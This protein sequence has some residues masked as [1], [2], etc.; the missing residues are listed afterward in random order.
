M[1][2]EAKSADAGVSARDLR[3]DHSYTSDQGQGDQNDGC[4][5]CLVHLFSALLL[6]LEPLLFTSAFH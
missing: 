3:D 5:L 2:H 1:N 6:M 4:A